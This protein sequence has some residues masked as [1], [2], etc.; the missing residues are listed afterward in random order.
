MQASDQGVAL[1][2]RRWLAA[3]AA[4]SVSLAGCTGLFSR[5]PDPETLFER[6]FDPSSTLNV[7]GTRRS[8]V[9]RGDEERWREIQFWERYPEASR[10]EVTDVGEEGYIFP[11]VPGSVRVMTES[12]TWNYDP[13]SERVITTERDPEPENGLAEQLAEFDITY[14]GTETF[15]GR[16]VHRLVLSLPD[17]SDDLIPFPI[18]P[19]STQPDETTGLRPTELQFLLDDE[20]AYPLKRVQVLTDGAEKLTVR[21]IQAVERVTFE[22]EFEDGLF[23]FDPPEGVEVH[24]A[25]T[26]DSLDHYDSIETARE[27]SPNPVPD[28]DVPEPYVFSGV[29]VSERED[30][31]Q[32]SLSYTDGL[33]D[34]IFILVRE[35]DTPLQRDLTTVGSVE[36]HLQELDDE[37]S[38]VWDCGQYRYRVGGVETEGELAGIVESIGCETDRN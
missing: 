35:V 18:L 19:V 16:E 26:P 8:V 28:A 23:V 33:G 29:T 31:V 14:E 27:N 12:K 24:E 4:S 10:Q 2:R 1:T 36:G 3:V 32:T 37:L 21:Q 15:V 6:A 17:D 25:N 20:Y 9:R 30:G 5:G 11:T 34:R 38:F 7:R 22:A 13:E